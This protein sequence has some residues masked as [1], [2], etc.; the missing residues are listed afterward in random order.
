M[1]VL[2]ASTS[3]SGLPLLL[4]LAE[5]P[6]RECCQPRHYEDSG[7]DQPCLVD[8]ESSEEGPEGAGQMGLLAD[9]SENLDGA[10][11]KRDENRQAGDDEVVVNLADRPRECPVV[12]E[13][14]EAAVRRVE[15]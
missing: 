11:K 13:I 15:Q 4:D 2:S 12:G 9:E 6:D 5:P 14:H 3:P 10:D 1:S 7:D 8:V